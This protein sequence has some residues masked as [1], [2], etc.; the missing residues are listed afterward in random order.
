M[1]KIYGMPAD[2][3][4]RHKILEAAM[5]AGFTV[6]TIYGQETNKLMPCSDLDTLIHFAELVSDVMEEFPS[7]TEEGR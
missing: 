2:D 5:V 4:K 6:G 1:N 7:A 3:A